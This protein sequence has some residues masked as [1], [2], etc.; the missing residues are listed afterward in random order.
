MN[1]KVKILL[2]ALLTQLS[3]ATI[4][5]CNSD[6]FISSSNLNPEVER[7]IIN[8]YFFDK[9]GF[10]EIIWFNTWYRG[11][12]YICSLELSQYSYSC[13]EAE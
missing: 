7:K 9:D 12:N 11:I 4:G 13:I 6:D 1:Q 3:L 5:L 10:G 8:G 2:S